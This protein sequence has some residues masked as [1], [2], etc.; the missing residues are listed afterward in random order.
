MKHSKILLC[1]KYS[2]LVLILYIPL[3]GLAKRRLNCGGGRVN[4]EM[5]QSIPTGR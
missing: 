4:V 5:G 3:I 2:I 1:C